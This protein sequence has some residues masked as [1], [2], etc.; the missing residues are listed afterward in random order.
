MI[1][2]Q[3]V[4]GPQIVV[5]LGSKRRVDAHPIMDPERIFVGKLADL[6]RRCSSPIPGEE[7]EYQA[8]MMAPLLR[9]FLFK[10]SIV[11][12]VKRMQ[13][14]KD[15]GKRFKI[16]FRCVPLTALGSLGLPEPDLHMAADGFAWVDAASP[17]YVQALPLDGFLKATVGFVKGDSLSVYDLVEYLANAAGA[18]H[19]E[20]PA[21]RTKGNR[22]VVAA[23]HDAVA[24]QGLGAALYALMGVA[25]VVVEGL[26]PL[27]D[28]ATQVHA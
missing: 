13:E 2:L 27:A 8:L 7:P 5:G 22:P 6:R 25:R 17:A 4:R 11:D 9:D 20:D 14:A 19:Y 23:F 24:V 21:D 3:T 16:S 26:Q 18:V 12:R 28:A 15:G 10:P 1:V